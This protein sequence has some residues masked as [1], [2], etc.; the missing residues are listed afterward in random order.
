MAIA[1]EEIPRAQLLV[2]VRAD[3][4]LWMPGLAQRR[5]HL[6]DDRLV[7]RVAAAFLRRVHTLSVHVCLQTTKHRI[8]LGRLVLLTFQALV[9]SVR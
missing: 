5:Y 7:A 9:R 6:A 3:E 4:V 1:F 2:A 8:Q